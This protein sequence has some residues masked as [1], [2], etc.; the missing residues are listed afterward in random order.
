MIGEIKKIVGNELTIKVDLDIE[1]YDLTT[2]ADGKPLT[3]EININDGRHITYVQQKKIFAMLHDISDYTGYPMDD[4]EPMMK[5]RFM[6][7]QKMP[8][9]FSMKDCSLT[10][11]RN[12]IRFL[13]TYCIQRDIPFTT[14]VWDE[15][16]S[17]YPLQHQ[18]LL[19]R[20]CVICGKP[21]ADLAHYDL[22]G[23]G[24]NRKEI[25]HVGLRAMTLCRKHHSLQH[26][27]G[28]VEFCQ[29]YQVKP[30]KMTKYDVVKLG[31][32]S[33]KQVDELNA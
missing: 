30:I 6:S 33:K 17:S 24:R 2:L 10:V 5:Y 19:K 15:I 28:L 23:S 31:L 9:F 27:I 32:M 11:A 3:A 7:T 12:F 1:K 21:H 26:S 4:I 14:K 13:I 25:N 16:A 8:E 20:L 22:V 18:C 29:M